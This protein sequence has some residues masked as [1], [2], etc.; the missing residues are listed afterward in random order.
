MSA[1]THFAVAVH[2]LAVLGSRGQVVSSEE[3]ARSINTHPVVVRRVL[4]KL[5]TSGIVRSIA[6]KHG[7]FELCRDLDA[8]LLADVHDAVRDDHAFR[9][10]DN[11]ENPSCNVSCHIKDVLACIAER[12]DGA[13]RDELAKTSLKDVIAALR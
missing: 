12:V 2:A 7:G 5:T 13:V 3:L 8:V 1:N 6:G 4:G 11:A 10:H 9:I